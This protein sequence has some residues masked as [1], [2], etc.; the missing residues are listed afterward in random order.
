M[1]SEL[2]RFLQPLPVDTDRVSDRL[3]LLKNPGYRE[4][5]ALVGDT[6]FL[7]DAT[8]GD[9]RG[10]LDSAWIAKLFPGPHPIV[11]VVTDLAWPHVAGIRYWVS[12]GA[13]VVSH[14]MSREFLER[15]VRR[16]WTRW[17][18]AL[19]RGRRPLRFR[20]VTDSL[21]LA[22]GEV[23]LHPID[24]IGSEGAL[25]GWFPGPRF[26]WAS[27]YIQD[28]SQPTQYLSEVAAAAARTRLSPLR[29]AAEHVP[30]TEW[31]TVERL[32]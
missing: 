19:E 16:R 12:R 32:R 7:F 11:L 28:L 1:S 2:P 3:F 15:V 4:A 5:V 18:D 13:T 30:L 8:Q 25:L 22:A 29:F 26:L 23:V 14:A 20:A 9:G 6:V 31:T 17:P 10:R 21:R 27:D 24:G